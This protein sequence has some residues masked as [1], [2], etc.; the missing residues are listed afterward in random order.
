MTAD[1]GAGGG[2]YDPRMNWGGASTAVASVTAIAA[3]VVAVRAKADGRRSVIAAEKSAEIAAESLRLQWEAAR[4]R[5]DLRIERAANGSRLLK[6]TGAAT[7]HQLTLH[8]D[9][10]TYFA[11]DDPLGDLDGGDVRVF[12]VISAGAPARLRFVWNGQG[13][14]VAVG[15]P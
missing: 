15:M 3:T 9:D 6:N 11:W 8:P 2:R 12:H 10:Q 14:Y 13:G 5:V 4:P 7:A 1:Y